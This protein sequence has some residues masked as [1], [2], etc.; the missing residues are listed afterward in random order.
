MIPVSPP[1]TGIKWWGGVGWALQWDGYLAAAKER[2]A[3]SRAMSVRELTPSFLRMW[4]KRVPT[5][6]RDSVSRVAISGLDRPSSTNAAI[7]CSIGVRLSHPLC[8]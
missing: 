6:R 3:D 1:E 5:V 2:R 8:A 4:E 7:F